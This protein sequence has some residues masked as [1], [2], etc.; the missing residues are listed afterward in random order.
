MPA[1][2]R[3]A[4]RRLPEGDA[5]AQ[6]TIEEEA[7]LECVR[8]CDGPGQASTLYVVTR[9]GEDSK[10][11]SVLLFYHSHVDIDVDMYTHIIV[12]PCHI[13]F[14]QSICVYCYTLKCITDDR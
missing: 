3:R 14:R 6:N 12:I 10:Q 4:Q 2:P 13:T 9:G 1:G 11:L 7:D 5:P 8:R